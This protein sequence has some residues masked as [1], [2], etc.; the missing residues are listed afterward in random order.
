MKICMALNDK[1]EGEREI[2]EAC[3]NK[4]QVMRK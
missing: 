1:G 2:M 4:T 3:E